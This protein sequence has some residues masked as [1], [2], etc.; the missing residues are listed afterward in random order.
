MRIIIASSEAVPYV[1]TG[2]LAD[3]A[4]ALLK[5]LRERGEQVSLI[6]P[7][8]AGIRECFVLHETGRSFTLDLGVFALHGAV[9]TSDTSAVPSAYFIECEELFNRPELYGTAYG[10]YHDNALRF[11]F[12]SKAILETCQIFNIRPDVIHC[13]DWQTGLIPLYLKDYYC[14]R[15]HFRE[16]ATVMTIHNLGYQGLFNK[17]DIRYTGLGWEYFT[18][19]K[20]EFH[21]MLNYLKA[22]LIYADLINTVSQTYAREILM[23]ENGFGLDSLLRARKADLYGIINGID[24][25]EFDPSL[26]TLLPVVYS[27]DSLDARAASRQALREQA[28]LEQ[29]ERPIIGVV[30]RFSSQKGLDLVAGAIE[31]LVDLG[32]DLVILGK[33]EEHYHTLLAGLAGQYPGRVSLTI[34]FS[35]QAA[36]LIYAG[37]DFFLMPSR[38]EPCGLGQLIALRYGAIP[39]ARRT[40]GLADTIRDYDSKAGKGTGFLFAE[41]SVAALLGAVRRALSVYRHPDRFRSLIREAMADDFSCERSASYYLML[42]RK[43]VMKVSR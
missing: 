18:I 28:G 19:D 25:G 14:D 5:E 27:R 24:Y 26:D 21:D 43:A 38:Y 41:Y 35:E 17:G 39:I 37:A 11:A 20:V 15:P 1:K 3:V 36:R 32:V 2:G 33:G 9:W 4:G 6:L 29:N 34:G 42:Y 7:L 13:N 22:G 8:Y 30:G 31:G 12:F 40:G 16:T 23:P 10:D